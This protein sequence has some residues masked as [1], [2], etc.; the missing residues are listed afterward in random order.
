MRVSVYE[1]LDRLVGDAADVGY[2]VARE[3]RHAEGIY[4]QNAVVSD[5][6]AGVGQPFVKPCEYAGF[7]FYDFCAGC[8]GH[9]VASGFGMGGF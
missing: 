7:Q 4:H 5:D 2:Q 8:E 6:D 3:R 9:R 1:V